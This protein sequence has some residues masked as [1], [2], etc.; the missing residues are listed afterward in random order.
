MQHPTS[1][2][3]VLSLS[4]IFL[5]TLPLFLLIWIYLPAPFYILW[6]GALIASEWS[7]FFGLVGLAGAML[8]VVM[9]WRKARWS[10]IVSIV[11][12]L[13]A[14]G[15]SL[16][17]Y[18][19]TF[20]VT[21]CNVEFSLSDYFVGSGPERQQTQPQTFTYASP[22]G[23][24]LQLDLYLPE[25]T[26]ATL[27]SDG[28]RGR[29]AMIVVHGGSWNSGKRSDFPDWNYW[30]ASIGIV[31]FDIDYRLAPQPNWRQA[32]DDVRSAVQWVKGHAAQFGIDSQRVG[33]MGRSAGGHLALLAAYTGVGTPSE[34]QAVISFYAPTDLTWAYTH[35][36]NQNV[37][38][39][40]ATL[41]RFIG[42][43]PGELPEDY[44]AASPISHLSGR[45]PPTFLVHGGHDQLVRTENTIRLLER[46]HEVDYPSSRY[47]AVIIPYAQHGFDYN[48]N[49]WGSQ[50][51]RQM[52]FSFLSTNLLN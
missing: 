25:S 1:V 10:G 42:G 20:T 36:A 44:R 24:P 45:I 27:T 14:A 49:G 38:D 30:L 17:P 8:G 13:L 37:I 4:A 6:L 3:R 32:T 51:S 31:V 40:P 35:P 47:Y 52:L 16:G 5:T 33:L 29:P 21:A 11:C 2:S 48:F 22:G 23:K 26:E 15:L 34:V 43:T 50:L 12:G 19:W 39:G 28:N 41:R 7:L 9:V 46:F 18:A